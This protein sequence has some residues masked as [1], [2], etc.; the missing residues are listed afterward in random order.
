MELPDHNGLGYPA[1]P[2]GGE[3][4]RPR[5]LQRHHTIQNSDDAYV[6]LDD[7]PGMSLVAG[8][9]LSSAR[10]S[11]AVLSQVSLTGS[12]Q[13]PDREDEECGERSGHE[14]LDL[15]D[16][17][18]LSSCYPSTCITDILLSYKHPEV[19]FSVE[20]AGV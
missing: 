17:Q 1:R 8:K 14:H 2:P 9:A 12:Q 11:D 15:T 19:S 7:L 20:Q 3:H 16:G 5:T 6:Q 10:M 13:L 4:H 18:H